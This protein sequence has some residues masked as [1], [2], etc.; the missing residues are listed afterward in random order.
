MGKNEE[1]RDQDA[2]YGR[3]RLVGRSR[4]AICKNRVELEHQ[5]LVFAEFRSHS[6]SLPACYRELF[7]SAQITA[8]KPKFQVFWR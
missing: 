7:T 1:G 6:R 5:T 3:P 8:Y 2:L 4:I